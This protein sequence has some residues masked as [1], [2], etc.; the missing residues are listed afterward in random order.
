MRGFTFKTQPLLTY[1]LFLE[2]SG[3][4]S[5]FNAGA[6]PIAPKLLDPGYEHSA[7]VPGLRG[8]WR[9]HRVDAPTLRLLVIFHHRGYSQ[10]LRTK[11]WGAQLVIRTNL[12]H[13]RLLHPCKP[14]E[15]HSEG[16][17]GYMS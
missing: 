15:L 10:L 13:L 12:S 14:P 3:Y 17:L 2:G 1:A 4:I 6:T 5:T 8:P 11:A 9:T 7:P 16:F